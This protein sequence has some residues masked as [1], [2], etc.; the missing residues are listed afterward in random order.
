MPPPAAGGR[1][2]SQSGVALAL[3]LA[4][5]APAAQPVGVT[6]SAA[7]AG[8]GGRGSKGG[9]ISGGRALTTEIITF[10]VNNAANDLFYA[11]L[12]P[13]A[14]AQC[15]ALC[16]AYTGCLLWQYQGTTSLCS[17]GGAPAQCYL[18]ARTAS[19]G[20]GTA[21]NCYVEGLRTSATDC[22]N[23]ASQY[24]YGAALATACA[25]CNLA[26]STFVS[27]TQGCRPKIGTGSSRAGATD[28]LFFLSGTE[29]EGVAAFSLMASGSPGAISYTTD[30]FG[31]SNGALVLASGS[32]L[33]MSGSSYFAD[34]LPLTSAAT[35]SAWV[36]CPALPVRTMSVLE[37]GAAGAPTGTNKV[38]LYVSSPS[39]AATFLQSAGAVTTL[40]QSA[41]LG[42]ADGAMGTAKADIA[43]GFALVHDGSGIYVADI[44]NRLV[45]FLATAT[46]VMTTIAGNKGAPAENVDGTGTNAHFS[47]LNDLAL[48]EAAGVLYVCTPGDWSVVRK[49][50]L[51]TMAVTTLAGSASGASTNID[52]VGTSATFPFAQA[53]A[54]W[55]PLIPHTLFV[56][57]YPGNI[58]KIDL[59]TATVTTLAGTVAG[60]TG[61]ADGWGTSAR[62]SNAAA[63]ALDAVGNIY[64]SDFYNKRVRK[65]TQFGLV[66]T[67]AGSGD[68]DNV[69]NVYGT[70]AMFTYVY[71][72]AV[73]PVGNV[74]VGGVD[75]G[76][77]ALRVIRA[78]D[79]FVTTV[80]GVYGPPSS[81]DGVGTAASFHWLGYLRYDNATGSILG[82]EQGT[83]NKLRRVSL[84]LNSAVG[85]PLGVCD[86]AFHHVAAVY[87]GSALQYYVD[88]ASF[89]APLST[90]SV[91]IPRGNEGFPFWSYLRIGFDGDI[92]STLQVGSSFS[93]ALAD[94]RVFARSLNST[95]IYTLSR[96]LPPM[97]PTATPSASASPSAAASG[98]TTALPS[99]SATVSS[100]SLATSTVSTSATPSETGSGTRSM[101]AS[102]T[103]S[104]SAVAT[105]SVSVS[106][107]MSSSI[108]ATPTVS[109]SATP[110]GTGYGTRS[111]SASVTASTSAVATLSVSPSATASA[112]A[113]PSG[114]LEV[115]PSALA[116]PSAA[117]TRTVSPSASQS[118]SVL[119]SPS[120]RLSM[121]GT[122]SATASLSAS[123]TS[124]GSN[125]ASASAP[126]SWST[127]ASLS[128]SATA[129]ASL[130]A[131]ASPTTSSSST[132]SGSSLPSPSAS[133]ST[134]GTPSATASLSR[135]SSASCTVSAT[136]PP[137]E[138]SSGTASLSSSPAS[139]VSARASAS[140]SASTSVSPSALS[141][142]STTPSAPAPPP[143]F[144]LAKAELTA[145]GPRV[146]AARL[147]ARSDTNWLQPAAPGVNAGAPLNLTLRSG[148]AGVSQ[149][150]PGPGAATLDA[151]TFF[152]GW[153][154]ANG[155]YAG[156]LF[157][158]GDPC[159]GQSGAAGGGQGRQTAIFLSC[160]RVPSAVGAPAVELDDA[161]RAGG[162]GAAPC[163]LFL[164]LAL[165]EVCGVNMT[166][167]AETQ[168]AADVEAPLAV[169]NIDALTDE[170][171]NAGGRTDAAFYFPAFA[172]GFPP[173]PAPA[174]GWVNV[175][176]VSLV[177]RVRT[178]TGSGLDTI[179]IPLIADVL[180]APLTAADPASGRGCAPALLDALRF[181]AALYLSV[182][183]L[184]SGGASVAGS[185]GTITPLIIG[186]GGGGGAVL[187][188]KIALPGGALLPFSP[189]ACDAGPGA[190]VARRAPGFYV[191]LQ[192][193]SA[194][195]SAGV[196][197][198]LCG[199][200]PG[201]GTFLAT[202]DVIV[203]AILGADA[204]PNPKF[205]LAVGAVAN[206]A[207]QPAGSAEAVPAARTG[208]CGASEALAP[209]ALA[210]SISAAAETAS[211]PLVAGFAWSPT[212]QGQR[213][214][215]DGCAQP[216]TL[217]AA[218][219]VARALQ[220]SAL[221]SVS[222]LVANASAA[223]A[224]ARLRL[225][226]LRA[227]T[228]G[229]AGSIPTAAAL[230]AAST[231]FVA[232]SLGAAL[233]NDTSQ[234]PAPLLRD[235]AWVTFSFL[236]TAAYAPGLPHDA[237]LLLM[238][239]A[240]VAVRAA[241][242]GVAGGVLALAGDGETLVA[243]AHSEFPT[244]IVFRAALDFSVPPQLA[245]DA[246][247]A[248][249][250]AGACGTIDQLV[251][252]PGTAAPATA[253]AGFFFTL[254][255]VGQ[256]AS[257]CAALAPDPVSS[258]NVAIVA[259]SILID[260]SE[261][262]LAAPAELLP[263]LTL[264]V[265]GSALVL[266][267]A[268][269]SARE[270]AAARSPL[271]PGRSLGEGG[272]NVSLSRLGPALLGLA[273][274]SLAPSLPAG[275]V[276][277]T[278]SLAGSPAALS[279][280]SVRGGSALAAP[281]FVMLDSSL[282]LVTRNS[283]AAAGGPGS[284]GY[285][286][287]GV[288]VRSNTSGFVLGSPDVDAV[289]RIVL[290]RPLSVCPVLPCADGTF[291]A[292][293]CDGLGT[294]RVCA[295]C[296]DPDTL[297]AMASASAG[298]EPF[299]AAAACSPAANVQCA[300]CS[301]ACPASFFCGAGPVAPIIACGAGLASAVGSTSKANCT[302][303][304][305]SFYCPPASP[306]VACPPER[307]VS[308]AGASHLENCS[309]LTAASVQAS[310]D[311]LSSVSTSAGALGA[312]GVATS[313]GEFL[314][315]PGDP[316]TTNSSALDATTTVRG[317]VIAQVGRLISVLAGSR[318]AAL[319]G[320]SGGLVA[321]ATSPDF[322][323]GTA[324]AA[325]LEDTSIPL[326]DNATQAAAVALASLTSSTSQ[327]SFAAAG[328]AMDALRSIALLSLPIN[329]LSGA[330]D[331][332]GGVR[333]STAAN[334]TAL[335]IVPPLPSETAS[336]FLSVCG[337]VASAVSA[338]AGPTSMAEAA[339]VQA[340]VSAA[341]GAVSAA[342][343]RAAAAGDP[344][345][346]VSAG[347]ADAFAVAG[348][349]SY[350]G[351]ALS[352]TVARLS[353]N[354]SALALPLGL[355]IAQCGGERGHAAPAPA[356]SASAAFLAGAARGA[357]A[358]RLAAVSVD[359]SFVQ[360]GRSPVPEASG[361]AA[362][363]ALGP[364]APLDTRVVSVV[365]QS[366]AGVQIAIANSSAPITLTLPLLGASSAA[367]GL[368]A[369]Y[370]RRNVSVACPASTLQSAIAIDCGAPV[371]VRNV[372]CAASAR[373]YNGTYLCPALS[374]KPQCVWWDTGS[375]AWSSAGC[376]A[377]SGGGADSFG[378][379]C[380]H[381]TAF[382]ARFAA[383]AA[384]QDDIF[385]HGADLF[386]APREMLAQFPHVFIIL[387]IIL[388][389]MALSLGIAT[390]LDHV[391]DRHFYDSLH[392]DPEIR[393]LA[394]IENLKGGVFVLDRVLDK[395]VDSFQEEISRARLERRA[396]IIAAAQGLL[397]AP[398]SKL[399]ADIDAAVSLHLHASS[400]AQRLSLG[401]SL[402]LRVLGLCCCRGPPASNEAVAATAPA[403]GSTS[404][405]A[406]DQYARAISSRIMRSFTSLGVSGGRN[407]LLERIWHND[408]T[409]GAISADVALALG[410]H[411]SAPAAPTGA[412]KVPVKAPVAA[413]TETDRAAEKD[414]EE[415]GNDAGEG[416][417][418]SVLDKAHGSSC[419]RAWT[420]R[421]FL[422]RTWVLDVMHEH[423]V[424][425]IFFRY[426]PVMSRALR[427]LVLAAA[428][429]G[430]LWTTAF[431]FAFVQEGEPGEA[432]PPLTF[433]ETI[434][435]AIFVAILQV[436]IGALIE[437]LSSRAGEAEF[438]Y[439][440]P[441]LSAE[442]KR[443]KEAEERLSKLSKEELEA[444]LAEV[445]GA[446]PKSAAVLTAA[447]PRFEAVDDDEDDSD[448]EFAFDWVDAPPQLQTYC[449]PLLRCCGRAP[450]QR[451]AYIARM[452]KAEA[453]RA[454][455]LAAAR[456]KRAKRAAAREA[457]RTSLLARLGL[458][459][460]GGESGTPRGAARSASLQGS[461]VPSAGPG[462]GAL[463]AVIAA[464]GTTRGDGSNAEIE[465]EG[466]GG[467]DADDDDEEAPSA[468]SS[469]KSAFFCCAKTI[470]EV[471]T[472]GAVEMLESCSESFGET[473]LGRAV[474]ALSEAVAARCG[475]LVRCC[476]RAPCTTATA[477]ALFVI[478]S[479]VAFW[480]W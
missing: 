93:G 271:A 294:E 91:V 209:I 412:T 424:L 442:L 351:D 454:A 150:L 6:A 320:S 437:F 467:D 305:P 433:S 414:A 242:D 198:A 237:P 360:N 149:V 40:W 478:W 270:L 188:V 229:S 261:P 371:G 58:R 98:S 107:T 430:D 65:V 49:V 383:F 144:G 318:A 81:V 124:P 227:P 293:H 337:N 400:N 268:S 161:G 366:R 42:Y 369:A 266:G 218:G 30:H 388:G 251:A 53:I 382:A 172:P 468:W 367:L 11:I 159:P 397:F 102:V 254:A 384:Q 321:N 336:L 419:F 292:V 165:P 323:N 163:Y 178:S 422:L 334:G 123:F 46:G 129:P 175:T 243:A 80:A 458:G 319:T 343:L 152:A 186:G 89:A 362:L 379:E 88:G 37:W 335:A 113:T 392:A 434:V 416:A 303:C 395:R 76:A 214:G 210:A 47:G 191:G 333:A 60:E 449:A 421:S 350:C 138:S 45:R 427:V 221:R 456:A 365:L 346:S 354:G 247:R 260:A 12:P 21:D 224:G 443:R 373:A 68:Y 314:N 22:T 380:D 72:I 73:D 441:F 127:A 101:S 13:S 328:S 439:R 202:P 24:S 18:K 36:R 75:A 342:V 220:R 70:N 200:S 182:E 340:K 137:T 223:L 235:D 339:D 199:A 154:V 355:P 417:S 231:A 204:P 477:L 121:T 457:L 125:T 23:P 142:P 190:G 386:V 234:A 38:S 344:P 56:S 324:L 370:S 226:V 308:P 184:A 374:V 431:L 269:F 132:G 2:W 408:G 146:L 471:D 307:P 233:V 249:P 15:S 158:R 117:A 128:A 148:L 455:A 131:A 452:R 376:V 10:G 147:V 278:W 9:S 103:A 28:T 282:R 329:V 31:L 197:K 94:L 363:G 445:S 248:S 426:D 110:S 447:S 287:G 304:A 315:A 405:L 69:V 212:Q 255:D 169:V 464:A 461:G 466:K 14:Y 393:F 33:A 41:G 71:G 238:L 145:S 289:F 280:M 4:L 112:S 141:T 310:I 463:V 432:L 109:T 404:F 245:A 313:I 84:A 460:S 453:A 79:A 51:A 330:I 211:P 267:N 391:G 394:T 232:V 195:R 52:A 177:V 78:S 205:C 296:S 8:T 151:G 208:A 256:G 20:A 194:D 476:R 19:G 265:G 193:R 348:N 387:G 153:L 381:L 55:P 450:E 286:S 77:S 301:L 174:T 285:A 480:L 92:P 62:F 378:C 215:F 325:L 257:N 126:A 236:G 17:A 459:A 74:Y 410:L 281:L 358:L 219:C 111:M 171:W 108:L 470:Y 61:Y 162:T 34:T 35:L 474:A 105:L 3:V 26:I 277:A 207:W 96:P 272:A 475:P 213:A 415:V 222:L 189:D 347:A 349:A 116:S 16:D 43:M 95:E 290:A 413:W 1:A 181:P 66:T 398:P 284:G 352:L 377:V 250:L 54:L 428:L 206:I 140:T 97:A 57:T 225:S 241:A 104:T 82:W 295:P 139:S 438:A 83:L 407:S 418:E 440:Y 122:A 357:S 67:L 372:S 298:G 423:L 406:G 25:S 39:S 217:G 244:G 326:S 401:T 100:S 44:N 473:W 462:A 327:L 135:S 115:S 402:A 252:S 425:S 368:Q 106:A 50:V 451:A 114:S 258:A 180:L 48:D 170:N 338:A 300:P 173:A 276:W 345:T 264:V 375:S 160:A 133:L 99:V 240:P 361:F 420:L 435:V 359:V 166:V 5:S 385:G 7:A 341:L 86:G 119:P 364:S 192:W 164:T 306:P 167:G 59:M 317:A 85:A 246:L 185:A 187:L 403:K 331:L 120:A 143:A 279:G 283:S 168:P 411:A 479:V 469:V 201:A 356:I 29:A 216:C 27:S 203:D 179:S 399:P 448:D 32:Y 446:K 228:L 297:C 90:A 291:E 183:T 253:A 322:L 118:G 299:F 429:I 155:S 409:S 436:P 64:V 274:A 134:S 390:E 396:E 63:L 465:K 156:I 444:E 302:S 389:L 239:S 311:I 472:E 309:A 262:A 157:S 230:Q 259:V 353:T 312:L 275:A 130:S 316:L 273:G 136:S 87:S 332:V 288:L 176:L 263:G 196:A